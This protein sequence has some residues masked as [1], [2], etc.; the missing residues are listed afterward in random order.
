MTMNT[1]KPTEIKIISSAEQRLDRNEEYAKRA[2]KFNTIEEADPD[3]LYSPAVKID[4]SKKKTHMKTREEKADELIEA[5]RE[6]LPAVK[7]SGMI[8]RFDLEVVL[9]SV[10]GVV[11]D[12]S[13]CITWSRESREFFSRV[14]EHLHAAIT[15]C[16]D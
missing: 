8:S 1:E 5:H 2:E 15:E 14:Y 6:S 4:A 12:N 7:I 16:L 3:H 13:N 11:E 9:A 10:A